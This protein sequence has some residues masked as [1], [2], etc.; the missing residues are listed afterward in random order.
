[1]AKKVRRKKRIEHGENHLAG[2]EAIK[3]VLEDGRTVKAR[4]ADELAI[5]D[6]PDILRKQART[7]PARL[8]FW[9]YQTERAL[10]ALRVGERVVAT[11]EGEAYVLQRRYIDEHTTDVPTEANIRARLDILPELNSEKER[12]DRLRRQYA[13]LRSLRD[14]LDHR[15]RILQR[16]LAPKQWAP[17][18]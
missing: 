2:I 14:A 16:L 17:S 7:A 15:A 18:G 5:S 1:M 4:M 10:H 3:V 9:S 8:A 12:L 6:D 11:Q 13:V